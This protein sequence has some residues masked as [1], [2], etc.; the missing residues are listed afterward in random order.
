M[1][2]E[3]KKEERDQ[4]TEGKKTKKNTPDFYSGVLRQVLEVSNKLFIEYF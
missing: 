4:K 2:S 1:S 3:E